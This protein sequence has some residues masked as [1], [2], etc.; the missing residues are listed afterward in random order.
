MKREITNEDKAKFLMQYFGQNVALYYGRSEVEEVD[1]FAGIDTERTCLLLKPLSAI[2]DEDAE[3]VAKIAHRVDHFQTADRGKS[4]INK[5]L[6][7]EDC[8]HDGYFSFAQV[9]NTID[10]LRSK[11]YALPYMYLSVEELKNIGWIK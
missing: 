10:F 6:L 9:G 5:M 2:T 4:Y 11:G 7:T 8:Y 1:E 3:Y